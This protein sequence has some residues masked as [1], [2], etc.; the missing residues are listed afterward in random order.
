[1]L[2]DV[3]SNMATDLARFQ[4]HLNAT[5]VQLKLEHR[6]SLTEK[7]FWGFEGLLI[8]VSMFITGMWYKDPTGNYE[9]ILACLGLAIPLIALGIKLSGKK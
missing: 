8:L 1:M 9:P 2:P 3:E 6:K 4:N 7:F 5:A